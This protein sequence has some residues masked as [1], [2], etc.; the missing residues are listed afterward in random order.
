MRL[1]F[2]N[3]TIAQVFTDLQFGMIWDITELQPLLKI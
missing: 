2:V 1:G 3:V